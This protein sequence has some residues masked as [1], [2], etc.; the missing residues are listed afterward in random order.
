[1]PTFFCS[2]A[3][4]I[5]FL[6]I[7]GVVYDDDY[8]SLEGG[9]GQ[10]EDTR[11][12]LGAPFSI[13]ERAL[14]LYSEKTLALS[15]IMTAIF[16]L[17]IGFLVG[18]CVSRKYEKGSGHGGSKRSGTRNSGM[19]GSLYMSSSDLFEDGSSGGGSSS[20]GGAGGPL[21]K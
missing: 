5:A 9:N 7:S 10:P 15:V 11:L 20:S 1:M 14:L 16:A 2:C 4:F 3:T 17:S 6:S 12:L 21:K 13:P 19:S 18:F 8:N